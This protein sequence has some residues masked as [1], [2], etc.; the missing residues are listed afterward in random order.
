M[1][2]R[3]V[4]HAG[5]VQNGNYPSSKPCTS[6]HRKAGST[7]YLRVLKGAPKLYNHQFVSRK[8]QIILTANIHEKKNHIYWIT[9]LAITN[10]TLKFIYQGE[11]KNAWLYVVRCRL[12]NETM[13][14]LTE[15]LNEDE[16]AFLIP[17]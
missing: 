2:G 4:R 11:N 14:N 5:V 15:T 6:A 16:M 17:S 12:Y 13:P 1:K 8:G 3:R 10:Y 7:A 9:Q